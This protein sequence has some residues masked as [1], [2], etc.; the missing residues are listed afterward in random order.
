MAKYLDVCVDVQ[1][2]YEEGTAWYYR[3]GPDGCRYGVQLAYISDPY[4][5]GVLELARRY[6]ND[7]EGL[8]YSEGL[9]GP[10]LR[11]RVVRHG[12]G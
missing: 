9:E 12:V 8:R 7:Q 11:R 1:L 10:A 3:Q 2:A 4:E 6:L 5:E